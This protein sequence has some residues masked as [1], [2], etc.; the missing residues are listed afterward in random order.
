MNATHLTAAALAASILSL[1][2]RTACAA[3][4]V[5]SP[6]GE[7]AFTVDTDG[8]LGYTLAYRGRE[9][10]AKSQLGFAFRNEKP[11]TEDFAVVAE[12]VVETGLV[13]AWQPVVRNRHADVRLAY[14]RLVL[15]LREGKGDRRRMDLTVNVYDD[16]VAFRYTLYGTAKAAERLV[17]DELTELRVPETSFAWCATQG[18]KS[19]LG[20]PNNSQESEFVKTPVSEMR[21]DAWYFSPLLVEIDRENYLAFTSACLDDYPGFMS[22]RRNGAIVTRLVPSPAEGENGVKARFDRR[23]D[24]AWRVIMVG[25]NPGQFIESEIIRA[26][27]P[28][29]AIA[30][31]SWIRPGISAWDHWWSGDVK[32]EM[33][34]VKE[35]VDFASKQGWPYMLVDWQW[36]GQFNRPDADITR[37]A[38]QIDMP[39][40]IAYAKARNVRL[41]LWIHS[42]D[43]SRNDA[44]VEA[45]RTYEKWGIAGVK[46]DFMDR[47]DREIANWYRRVVKHAADCHLLVD[48][49]GAFAPDGIDRTYPNQMTREGVL[50]EEFSKFSKRITPKHNVT[51]AFTRLLAGA[52][53]YTPG[54][55]LNVTPEDFKMQKP[56]LV[57]NTRVAELSKFV[58]YESPWCC[59]CD[60]PTNVL[61]KAGAEFVAKVPTVW[62]DTRFLGGYPGEYVALARRSGE[63]WYVAVMGGDDARE[64]EVDLTPLKAAG[65]ELTFW[66]D[67]EKATDVVRGA[68]PYPADGRL[69]V[70]LA[71]GGGYVT[72]L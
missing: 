52:M 42:T 51:L 50:G 12:P 4:S 47:Y 21:P 15:K 6:K 27:N 70:K 43:V 65:R 11:M 46:I 41:V 13:E 20:A 26:V 31:T 68:A 64:V 45:F 2:A 66:A 71:R 19:G 53:D 63:R 14:N 54:G 62:D 37:P 32:M 60:H 34:V 69:K 7:I 61:G 24:T 30:D 36:Y 23:F 40:L 8:K 16:G 57:M 38:P 49:H 17:T 1:A 58:V 22:A 10:V 59:F 9:L 72:V 18:G 44:Y 28:P 55:F 29:C 39:E 48:F 56:T 5:T 35:Y 33:P 67:G 3:Y 25:S